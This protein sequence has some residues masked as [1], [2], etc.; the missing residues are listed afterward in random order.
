MS[1]TLRNSGHI[2]DG[3]QFSLAKMEITSNSKPDFG[4]LI[5]VIQ[6]LLSH[7][8]FNSILEHGHNGPGVTT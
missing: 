8:T 1:P 7:S 5:A 3:L 6:K 4:V 2:L